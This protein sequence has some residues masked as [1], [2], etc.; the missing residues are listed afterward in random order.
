MISDKLLRM[1]EVSILL[2]VT[3]QTLRN[4]SKEGYVQAVVGKGGQ[5]R[6][7]LSEV[8]RLMNF[9]THQS[10][11]NTCLIYGRVNRRKSSRIGL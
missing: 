2:G 5:C 3:S 6:F 7:N 11:E 8:R 4:W 10:D 1:K 9:A